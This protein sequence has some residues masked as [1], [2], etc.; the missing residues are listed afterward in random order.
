MRT[1]WIAPLAVAAAVASASP[2]LA[3]ERRFDVP[4]QKVDSAISEFGRQAGIQ[5][6]APSRP[7]MASSPVHGLLDVRLALEMLLKNTDLG[8]ATFQNG[9]LLV[10][11][12]PAH[13]STVNY[14]AS[15]ATLSPVAARAGDALSGSAALE[16][17]EG[18]T[19]V[20]TGTRDPGQTAQKSVSPISVISA[21]TLQRTGQGDLRD[22]LTQ[23][24]P[25][26]TRSR[27]TSG[28]ANM[29]DTIS[30]RGLTSDQ[31][32]ILV[33]GKRRHTTSVIT[34]AVGPEDG[35]APVDLGLI[36]T[37][38]IDHIEVLQDGAAALYGSDAIAGVIN[39]I[40]KSDRSGFNARALNGQYYAGD[41][42]NSTENA[43]WGHRLADK[44]YIDLAAEYRH[45]DHTDRGS[46]D[47]RVGTHANHYMG[48]PVQNRVA[49]S[50]NAS[51][52]VTSTTSLYS[53]ATYA[54]RRAASY[55][56]YRVPSSL[57]Q[58]FPNGY[59]PLSRVTE[60]D[61]SFTGG[62]K[63]KVMGWDWDFSSTYG[64]DR[65]SYDLFDSVNLLL[66]ADTGST[67]TTF[68]VMAYG[69]SQWTTDLSLRRYV[70]VGFL[71]AP[72]NV[73]FGGQFRRDTYAVDPG[74]PAS[75]YG[76]GTQGQSG[77]QPSSFVRAH[78]N[79]GS[80]YIDL[81]TKI[82]PQWQ[83]AMAGRFESYSD[84]G[85]V[86][87]GKVST[88]YDFNRM[89]AVRGTV[90]NGFRAP[91]MQE[92]YYTSLGVTPNGA[93]GVM[94]VNSV[95][96]KMLGAQALKPERS[97]NYSASLLLT[98]T[99]RLHITLDAYQINIR[100]RIVKG[101][102]YTGQ[103]AINALSAQGIAI[104]PG[105][106]PSAVSVQYFSNGA[107]TRT[108]G[109]DITSSYHLPLGSKTRYIDFDLAANLNDTKVTRVGTDLNGNALLGI[110]GVAYL[111]TYFPKNKVIFGGHLA[112]DKIDFDL[113]EIRW[114][115]ATSQRQY[116]TGADAYSTSVLYP[117]YNQPKWQTNLEL[118]YRFS[119]M[120]RASVG[121]T[122]L[123]DARPT[124]APLNT[125]YAGVAV[126]DTGVQQIGINGGF[127]YLSLGL[128]L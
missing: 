66:Y 24:A 70:P 15:T 23:L 61:F 21:Q 125:V 27:V 62:I 35:T 106:L 71:A 92:Q 90:S 96:A 39:I 60:N 80:A 73:A 17:A 103:V 10:K 34:D 112:H 121:A 37:S 11:P 94:A 47:T 56:N 3:Q 113:H 109:L 30:L 14:R 7:N 79:V 111:S 38:A 58:V 36:P 22:A 87:T 45:Q 64:Q 6:I 9:V 8:I 50:Y 26:I 74:E 52:D 100:D 95:A 28:N 114:G 88:R 104:N 128:K 2:A 40:L 32:L 18:E 25:S 89:V 82:V 69:N 4:A 65:T 93:S 91:N 120:F 13:V 49:L 119:P 31:T 54:H 124:R 76:A 101:G 107:D 126:Y 5:I 86:L 16:P 67:P 53:F 115:P 97:T 29:V 46:I 78:R 83:L 110:Q 63:G 98:P 33:N 85:N 116:V 118:G 43:S 68:H 117:L 42:F 122:N 84:V 44:G 51:Y 105:T 108:R 72:I 12:V 55:Q 75:Y 59:S 41:G 81:S 102:V 1:I 127:Y 19:I 77:L 20:V 48:D 123:F 57:P 99:P